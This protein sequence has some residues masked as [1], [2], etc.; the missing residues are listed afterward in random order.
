MDLQRL[1]PFAADN[2]GLVTRH[3]AARVG[4]S[5]AAWYRAV[6]SGLLHALHPN[7]ARMPGSPAT[8]EQRIAAAVLAAQP[9]AMA[10]HR[11]AAH[12]WGIPR[13]DDDPIDVMLVE[14]T[15][16]LALDGVTLHRPRDDKDLSPVLRSNVRTSNILRL[17]CDL[18]AVDPPGVRDAVLHIVTTGIASPLAL[19]TAVDVHSRRGRHGV[20]AFREALGEFVIDNKPV[21]SV[22]ESKMA[23]VAVTY[24][25]PPLKFH[26]TVCGYEVDFLVIGTPVVLECDGWDSH[27]RN[28]L[29]FE[30][31]RHRDATLLAAGFI[32]IRFTWRQLTR[33]PGKVAQRVREIVARFTPN[34]LSSVSVSETEDNQIV[35]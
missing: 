21:D 5:K 2:H 12:L 14:R 19:R 26:A 34:W 10:S 29:Q 1:E 24:G 15:R 6:G 18:G 25:L 31:D 27:G 17:L 30:R 3:A 4:I 33:Q 16:G 20:P 11:S 7:V 9:G 8:R 32:T 22:L 35:G 28:R 23:E 13:P